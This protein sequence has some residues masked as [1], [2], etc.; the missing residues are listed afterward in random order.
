MHERRLFVLGERPL[1]AQECEGAVHRIH[2]DL[3]DAAARNPGEE[4][5][6]DRT[7]M[8]DLIEFG[9]GSERTQTRYAVR[10]ASRNLQQNG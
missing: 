5:A 2:Q 8:R 10:Y 6:H 9:P 3:V 1:L 4:S 7:A